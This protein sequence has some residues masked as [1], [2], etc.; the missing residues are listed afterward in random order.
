MAMLETPWRFESSQPHHALFRT[1]QPRG[2]ITASAPA[3]RTSTFRDDE[4]PDP[5][6]L[7]TAP[8]RRVYARHGTHRPDRSR[9]VRLRG[10]D[11]AG[12]HVRDPARWWVVVQRSVHSHG[13]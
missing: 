13:P 5:G 12:L 7:H 3:S 11:H 8:A 9:D 6:L 4:D 10:P 2:P 1:G